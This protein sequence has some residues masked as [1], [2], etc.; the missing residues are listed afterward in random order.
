MSL[1]S[2]RTPMRMAT[3]TPAVSVGWVVACCAV[4]A[5]PLPTTCAASMRPTAHCRRGSGCALSVSWV[6]EVRAVGVNG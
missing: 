2:S 1:Q 4:T 6:G 3:Q 5:A